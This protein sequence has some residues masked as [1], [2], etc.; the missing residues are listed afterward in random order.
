MNFKKFKKFFSLKESRL[1]SVFFCTFLSFFV[2]NRANAAGGLESLDKATD[3][4]NDIMDWLFVFVGVG[5]L[6]YIIYLVAMALME[7]KSWNDVIMGGV[8]CAVAGGIVYAGKWALTLW[9]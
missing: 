8:Y 1:F 5:A 3:A 9:D 6:V 7:K 2:L 4:L